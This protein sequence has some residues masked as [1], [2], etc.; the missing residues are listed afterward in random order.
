MRL[1]DFLQMLCFREMFHLESYRSGCLQ[2]NSRNLNFHLVSSSGDARHISTRPKTAE[3]SKSL[4]AGRKMGVAGADDVI[5]RQTM[6]RQ[7][8]AAG[9]CGLTGAPSRGSSSKLDSFFI[10]SQSQLFLHLEWQTKEEQRK[11]KSLSWSFVKVL[12]PG[13]P[14]HFDST[15]V[16]AEV[17]LSKSSPCGCRCATTQTL[18]FERPKWVVRP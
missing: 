16:L 6:I 10:F 13:S 7:R 8:T 17:F 14:L 5:W 9:V 3:C 4:V 18:T 12:S 1:A 11:K 2:R 15:S